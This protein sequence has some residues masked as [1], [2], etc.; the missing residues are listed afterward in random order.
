MFLK[1]AVTPCFELS[2]VHTSNWSPYMDMAALDFG[3]GP[4][5][6]ARVNLYYVDHYWPTSQA[7][8]SQPT[9][10]RPAPMCNTLGI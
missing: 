10:G 1:G 2:G 8:L 4:C 9:T 6:G 3:T 7:R 5:Q